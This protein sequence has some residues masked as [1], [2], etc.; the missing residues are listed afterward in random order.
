MATRVSITKALEAKLRQW[1]EDGSKDT[2]GY[3]YIGQI[4]KLLD[5]EQGKR[6]AGS[7]DAESKSGLG[8]K[9]LV[10]LLRSYLGDALITPPKPNPT[11]IVKIV[12]KAKEQGLDYTNVEKVIS[13][14]LRLGGERLGSGTYRL[15][16]IVYNADRYY[17]AGGSNEGPGRNPA[18]VPVSPG[19]GRKAQAV[20]SVYTGRNDG[21]DGEEE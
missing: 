6:V 8:Y 12:N 3:G 10:A 17:A 11:F 13:G 21:E 19:D 1:Y 2:D 5:D 4:I 14:L 7:K 9:E 20:R 16:D 15:A 18:E